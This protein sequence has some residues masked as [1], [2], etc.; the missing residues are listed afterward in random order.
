MNP[1][2]SRVVVE[3]IWRVDFD[4]NFSDQRNNPPSTEG[5]AVLL[6]ISVSYSQWQTGQT[7]LILIPRTILLSSYLCD[8]RPEVPSHSC[9]I[10]NVLLFKSVST[11]STLTPLTQ[12]EPSCPKA[13]S[14]SA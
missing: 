7:Y 8:W 9:F 10:S 2:K 11:S 5:G 3:K 1:F 6:N 12:S 13:T 4:L 14:Y